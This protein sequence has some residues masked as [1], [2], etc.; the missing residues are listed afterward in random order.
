MIMGDVVIVVAVMRYIKCLKQVRINV[1]FSRLWCVKFYS[2]KKNKNQVCLK[3]FRKL[4]SKKF[5]STSVS[6]KWGKQCSACC[7]SSCRQEGRSACQNRYYDGS[8]SC[9]L[10]SFL[11]LFVVAL[12]NSVSRVQHCTSTTVFVFLLILWCCSYGWSFCGFHWELTWTLH[13]FCPSTL[14]LPFFLSPSLSFLSLSMRAI[15]HPLQSDL[16]SLICVTKETHNFY[17]PFFNLN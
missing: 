6:V 1:V 9:W 16:R 10:L 3:K 8:W 17:P 2:G 15:C 14:S 5:L 4:F 7:V 12:F 11:C 13:V